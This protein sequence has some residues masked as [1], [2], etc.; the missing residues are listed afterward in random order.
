MNIL[1]PKLQVIICCDVRLIYYLGTPIL[2]PLHTPKKD[3]CKLESQIIIHAKHN[4]ALPIVND[5][6]DRWK[7]S[8]HWCDTCGTTRRRTS[9][10]LPPIVRW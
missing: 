9:V 3:N 6:V 8:R 1:Q 4:N 10:E 5:A 2:T 7:E